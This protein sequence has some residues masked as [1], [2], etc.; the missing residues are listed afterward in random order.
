M[1]LLIQRLN[2]T[3]ITTKIHIKFIK[4]RLWW[5]PEAQGGWVKVFK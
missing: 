4:N 2:K 5:L 3:I 1:I